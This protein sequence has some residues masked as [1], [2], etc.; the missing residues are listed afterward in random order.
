MKQAALR[1]VGWNQNVRFRTRTDA[2]LGEVVAAV[3]ATPE[4][5]E[6]EQAMVVIHG[7][8]DVMNEDSSQEEAI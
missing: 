6:A 7:S 2:T 1:V 3:D 5:W 4:V 8:G